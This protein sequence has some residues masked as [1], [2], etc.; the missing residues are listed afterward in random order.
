MS[1]DLPVMLTKIG[2]SQFREVIGLHFED[3]VEGATIESAHGRTITEADCMWTTILLGIQTPIHLNKDYA[4][5]TEFGKVLVEQIVVFGISVGLHSA[6][7]SGQAAVN[8]E[9]DEL[10]ALKPVHINDTLY[11]SSKVLMVRESKSRPKQ[12]IVKTSIVTK[13]Q[14]GDVVHTATRTMLVWKRGCAPE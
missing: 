13:N 9:F 12:G 3:F 5:K 14:D 1:S 2:E 7:I 8:L 4:S 11:V 10:R 6:L